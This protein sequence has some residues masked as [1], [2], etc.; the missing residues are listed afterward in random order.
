[1]TG[2]VPAAAP[3]HSLAQVLARPGTRTVLLAGSRDPNAK[4]TMVL[5]DDHGPAFVVKVPTTARAAEVVRREGDLLYALHRMGLGALAGTIP[6]PTGYVD[7]DG[8][9]ALVTTA[10]VGTPMTARYHA[11]RHTARPSRVRADFVAAGSWLAALQSRTAGRSAPVTLL[12]DALAVLATRFPDHPSWCPLRRVLTRA[13]DR[14]SRH[15]TPRTVVQG[16]YWFGNLL[17]AGDR[18]AGD[19]VAGV[20]DWEAGA[21]SGEPLRDVARLAVSYAL[22]LDRHVR[23]GGR[24]PGHPGLRADSWGVGLLYAG[25]GQGWFG[26]LVREYASA[27]LDR[28][29]VPASLW[30][31]VL[32]AGIAEVAADADHPDFARQHLDLLVELTGAD[33]RPATYQRVAGPAVGPVAAV[34]G[35]PDPS[36]GAAT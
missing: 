29:G 27:A 30:P 24:V 9:P 1:V 33:P 11:W 20:V 28:L 31:D 14:L 17:I 7:A 32:L 8:L 16:D 23:P 2:P 10:L 22:Y 3:V 21:L 12:H 25:R 15:T 26:S 34:D 4:V 36:P 19:R 5:L 18:V 6:R 13:A 35:A